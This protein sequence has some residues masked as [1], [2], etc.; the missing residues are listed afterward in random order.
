MYREQF[1]L[2]VAEAI[3]IHKSQGSSLS[4]V[5]VSL[6][7]RNDTAMGY[8]AYSRATT[9]SGLFIIGNFFRLPKAKHINDS[10]VKEIT[11]TF[12]AQ[13]YGST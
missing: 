1:P 8:V 12:C 6:G 4:K 13:I 7:N 5:V 2:K 3:T 9:I 10:T 11:L